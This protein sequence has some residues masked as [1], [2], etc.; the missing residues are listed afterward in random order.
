[1]LIKNIRNLLLLPIA[2]AYSSSYAASA[3]E[4]V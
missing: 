3:H 2:L 4:Q 1:M